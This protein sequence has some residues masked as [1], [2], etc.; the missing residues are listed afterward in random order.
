MTRKRLLIP[1]A[2]AALGALGGFGV[3]EARQA[4]GATSDKERRHEMM[5]G[6]QMRDMGRM[7]GRMMRDAEMREMHR[8]M[9]RMHG[10]MMRDSE[11]REMHQ[12]A[13]RDPDMRDMH[14]MMMGRGMGRM[15]AGGDR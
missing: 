15:H 3:A 4:S 7:H 11:M 5:R 6:S 8:E 10:R 9:A 2:V 14:R 12:R 13:M 1:V